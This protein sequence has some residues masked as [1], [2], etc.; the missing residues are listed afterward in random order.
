MFFYSLW[1]ATGVCFLC[2]LHFGLLCFQGQGNLKG[3]AK[4][5]WQDQCDVRWLHHIWMKCRQRHT[6]RLS[7]LSRAHRESVFKLFSISM[8]TNEDTLLFWIVLNRIKVSCEINL[9]FSF[10]FSE[11]TILPQFP[12]AY[13]YFLFPLLKISAS[14]V[15]L[16]QLF[17]WLWGE[18]LEW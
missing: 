1:F 12:V 7:L 6:K 17:L 8:T 15:V 18:S 2:F 10:A 13:S 3:N 9:R 14:S 4:S 16:Y 5:F 11:V